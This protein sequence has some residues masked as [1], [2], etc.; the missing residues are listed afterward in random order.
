MGGGARR[1]Y[2]L[3]QAQLVQMATLAKFP[4][5]PFSA[6]QAAEML[7]VDLPCAARYLRDLEALRMIVRIGRTSDKHARLR[8]VVAAQ[9]DALAAR[10]AAEPILAGQCAGCG[11]GGGSGVSLVIFRKKLWCPVC[12]MDTRL[13]APEDVVEAHCPICARR[14]DVVDEIRRQGDRVTA[15]LVATC[16]RCQRRVRVEGHTTDAAWAALLG[17]LR[18]GA[19]RASHPP[20]AVVQQ[21]PVA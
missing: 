2:G 18:P 16:Y 13:T 17:R 12:L 15:A 6:P 10:S 19:R 7:K 14:M 8:Y 1:H 20:D 11:A 5:G 9:W 21:H 4:G 3:T